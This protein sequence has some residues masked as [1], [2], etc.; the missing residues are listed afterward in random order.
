MT[1]CAVRREDISFVQATVNDFEDF[2]ITRVEA[3][4]EVLKEIGGIHANYSCDAFEREFSA[5]YAR[6]IVVSG[7]RVGFLIIKPTL[8]G[9]L[10]EHLYVRSCLQGQGIGTAVLARLIA[11]AD[12]LRMPLRAR[13]L[14]GSPSNRLFLQRGFNLESENGWLVYY[15]RPLPEACRDQSATPQAAN[16][17]VLMADQAATPPVRVV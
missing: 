10:L 1:D 5:T 14:Q 6:H 3:M 12:A 11:E 13:S 4:R 8:A 2:L 15:I 17:V 9:L 16:A 7:M